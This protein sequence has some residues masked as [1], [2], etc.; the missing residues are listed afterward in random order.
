MGMPN[1]LVFVRHGNSE[2]NVLQAAAKKGDYS[3]HTE[4]R[5]TVPDR[6]WRL[7]PTGVVQAQVAGQWMKQ[8]LPLFDRFIVSPYV[9]TRETAGYL[10][11]DNA[12]WEENRAV[13][14]R[15]WGMIGSMPLEN[16]KVRWPESALLKESDPLYW[17]A[18]SG[19]SVA[20]L[21]EGRVRSLAN[22]LHRENEHSN[23][24]V[25][26]HGEFIQ[27]ILVFFERWSDEDFIEFDSDP[28]RK[29]HNCSVVHFTRID[30]VTGELARKLKWRRIAYP[31]Q[32]EDN[33]WS[34]FVE[35]WVEFDRK[36]Y[37]SE[38]LLTGIEQYPH[39]F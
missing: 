19:E 10:D 2:A 35:P 9:R 1:N 33:T 32:T 7:T 31:V 12:R 14:E 39:M 24:V 27:A 21:A 3:L 11:L 30:P 6:K 5:V 36:Y 13:R 18:P 20:G 29:I 8:N 17:Q 4:E 25:T 22:T 38:A 23:V 15:N 16:F 37:T 26:T 28:N 34:M